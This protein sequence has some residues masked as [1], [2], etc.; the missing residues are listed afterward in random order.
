[1]VS[2]LNAQQRALAAEVVSGTLTLEQAAERAGVPN[3]IVARWV[4]QLIFASAPSL[5]N[6]GRTLINFAQPQ[7]E[8]VK[9]VEVNKQAEEVE[10]ADV[11]EADE[12][13]RD[14]ILCDR[15]TLPRTRPEIDE[16]AYCLV[17]LTA[18][19]SATLTDI[20][21]RLLPLLDGSRSVRQIF[22]ALGLNPQSTR[23]QVQR[24]LALGYLVPSSIKPVE[25]PVA[26]SAPT[27]HS[28]VNIS[29]FKPQ[30]SRLAWTAAIAALG[31]AGTC[32]YL[33]KAQLMVAAGLAPAPKPVSYAAKPLDPPKTVTDVEA[34]Q[35][36]IPMVAKA[37]PVVTPGCPEGMA[38]IPPGTF[39]MGVVSDAPL[40]MN[41][42]PT[43]D[44]EFKQGFC[45]DRV[46]VTVDAYAACVDSKKC[47]QASSLAHW[48]RGTTKPEV[49]AASRRL[50]SQQCNAGAEGRGEHPINCISWPQASTYCSAQG[51][52]LP[53]EAQWEYA[54]RGNAGRIYPWGNGAPS[55]NTLN[56]CGKECDAW[57]TSVGLHGEVSSVLYAGDDTYPGTAPAGSFTAGATPEGLLDLAGNVAEWT[58]NSWYEYADL[59]KDPT[60]ERPTNGAYHVVRGGAFNSTTPAHIDASLRVAMPNATFSHAIG[61]RC[62][63]DPLP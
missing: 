19:Q 62:A 22:E 18:E 45:M 44:I 10:L 57:H 14:S 25:V 50:H 63:A 35:V 15:P 29:T 38:F 8:I 23:D 31:A 55:V 58:A 5:E 3:S 46:E 30:R 42:K 39:S 51:Y 2:D 36:V 9:P 12:G 49:W 27:R 24:L 26:P 20:E 59:A 61:F 28:Y 11:I 7:I 32:G 4:S 34:I 16:Q 52:H 33:F 41:S 17:T 43:H 60:F 47:S 54:A 21:P 53:T 6:R 1:M 56:G 40:L 13:E 48:G 37:A